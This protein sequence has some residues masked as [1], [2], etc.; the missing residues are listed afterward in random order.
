MQYQQTCFNVESWSLYRSFTNY[1]LITYTFTV[2]LIF[3]VTDQELSAELTTETDY[4]LPGKSYE[5]SGEGEGE[6]GGNA[7][8]VNNVD[9]QALSSPTLGARLA[10][11]LQDGE[12]NSG[13][14]ASAARA[15]ANKG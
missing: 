3:S 11:G 13:R 1:D 8:N 6:K 14:L 15:S 12:I 9:G 4:S 5:Q 10:Q 2:E 7:E